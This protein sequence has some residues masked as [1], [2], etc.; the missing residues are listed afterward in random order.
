MMTLHAFV[1][2]KITAV[3]AVGPVHVVIDQEGTVWVDEQAAYLLAV[4]DQGIR[5]CKTICSGWVA[6][7]P[8]NGAA[9]L[10]EPWII[11]DLGVV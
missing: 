7:L 1:G 4:L 5:A 9:N 6:L 3:F 11:E 10:A 8:V 2:R